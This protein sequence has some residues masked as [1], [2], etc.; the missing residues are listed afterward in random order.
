MHEFFMNK[1]SHFILYGAASFG[2]VLYQKLTDRGAMIDAYIDQRAE[3]ICRLMGVPVYR[4][5]DIANYLDVSKAI[6]IVSVKNVFEHTRIAAQLVK[7]GLHNLLY[8]PVAVL[9]NRATNEDCVIDM[10]YEKIIAGEL[11]GQTVFVPCTEQV[12]MSF[13][14]E[15]DYVLAKEGDQVT[16]PVPLTCLFQKKDKDTNEDERNILCYFP[17]IQ[18]FKY[19]QGDITADFSYYLDYCKRIATDLGSFEITKSW[20]KNVI[21]NRAEICDRMNLAYHLRQDFFVS[22]AP[23]AVWNKDGYFNIDEGQHRSAFLASKEMMFMPVKMKQ[24]DFKH[25]LNMDKAEEVLHKIQEE[26][27]NELP[28]PIEHPKFYEYPCKSTI[29]FYQFIFKVTEILCR[30]YYRSPLDNY[31]EEKK[32]YLSLNDWGILGRYFRRS[33]ANVFENKNTNC[34]WNALLD[35]LFYMD[36]YDEQ[37]LEGIFDVG[38]W[39]IDNLEMMYHGHNNIA[40]QRFYIISEDQV[41]MNQWNTAIVHRGL[42][43]DKKM[44][45]IYQ[46]EMGD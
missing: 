30:S 45:V 22:G 21:R 1:D 6:V 7:Y 39:Q 12:N 38:I 44:C 8:K 25:W 13:R 42:V 31:L 28:V 20:E 3:E 15:S 2:S 23:N 18:L 11:P 17:H 29:F 4:L 36:D 26:Q 9:N 32:I 33:R 5:S 37:N 34:I 24:S 43:G 35:E 41:D 14:D 19:L 40:K 27:I 10:W 16:I 46:N